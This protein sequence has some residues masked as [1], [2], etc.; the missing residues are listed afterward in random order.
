MISAVGI[1]RAGSKHILGIEL[2]ATENAAAVKALLT[3]LGEQGLP[4]EV[5]Y[6]FV[7]DAAKALRAGIEEV[8]GADQPVQRCRN[9]KMRNVID[10]LPGEQHAQTLNL[11]RAA[12]KLTN[13]DERMKRL[14]QLAQISGT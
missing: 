14:E 12:S 1:D 8:F 13:A 4:T 11:M 9:Q 7:I 10:E 5:K 6:L 3:R 2:G